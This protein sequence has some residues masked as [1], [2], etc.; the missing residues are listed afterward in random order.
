M[1]LQR[2]V[3]GLLMVCLVAAPAFVMQSCASSRPSPA[4]ER[5]EI[6][7]EHPFVSTSYEV[8]GDESC[9]DIVLKVEIRF[10]DGGGEKY[11]FPIRPRLS[12][13]IGQGT[14]IR[15]S[16]IRGIAA[17]N[18][19]SGSGYNGSVEIFELTAKTVTVTADFSWTNAKHEGGELKQKITLPYGKPETRRL[20]DGATIEIS[21]REPK[22][23]NKGAKPP[24]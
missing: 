10:P 2:E 3:R 7:P 8:V 17:D 5:Y 9:A 14:T 24:G 13:D 16:V 6:S 11:E 15:G 21:W 22:S 12:V 23:T 4:E 1:S 19:F 20:P 18:P